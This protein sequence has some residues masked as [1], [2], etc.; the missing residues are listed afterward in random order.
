MEPE[1]NETVNIEVIRQLRHDIRNELSGMILCIE[2]L[3]YE[4]ANAPEDQQ[5]YMKSIS[6]GCIHIDK[7]LDDIGS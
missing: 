5:Y 1:K 7:F 3:R 4:L 6:E 2:Q